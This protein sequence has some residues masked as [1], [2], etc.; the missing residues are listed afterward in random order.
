MGSLASSTADR[1][2]ASR[3]NVWPDP[4]NMFASFQRV[5]AL[6]LAVALCLP[7]V[8]AAQA[9]GAQATGQRPTRRDPKQAQKAL[10]SGKGA[11]AAGR[12]E[13]A[14]AAYDRATRLDPL[15]PSPLERSALLRSRMVHT[16]VDGAERLALTGELENAKRE[17]HTALEID[18]GNRNLTER[19]SQIAEMGP[20]P[21]PAAEQEF[22]GLPT[23]RPQSGTHSF[24]LRGDVQVLYQEVASA[25][26]LK[27]VFDPELT[28]RTLA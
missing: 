13:E 20:T 15:D 23:L 14:L 8:A 2:P 19:L 17:L 3:Y 6:G 25:F 11:E 28:S 10:Q 5:A 16:R 1:A 18:P 7:S 4:L 9:Q 27:V 12:L 24:N 21:P 22:A 26:G